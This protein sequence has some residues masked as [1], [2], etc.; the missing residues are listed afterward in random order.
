MTS[1]ARQPY[2]A[3]NED[4]SVEVLIKSKK[5]V[6]AHGEVFTPGHM[7]NQMLDLVQAELETEPDFVDKTF[8]EPSAGDGNFLIAILNR[9]LEA[10]TVHYPKSNHADE[11][12][13]ALAS[14]YGIELLADNHQ[15]AQAGMLDAFVSFHEEH[16]VPCTP[17]TDLYSA[18][19]F[20]IKTNIVHGNTL[21]GLTDA[22]DPIIF[23]WWHRVPEEE[24]TVQR[25]DFALST[26]RAES[27]GA[28]DFNIYTTYKPCRIDRVHQE[29]KRQ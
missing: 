16:G 14:I 13:F 15:A 5:R 25:E 6:R 9:K 27:Q 28:I 3:D 18:A 21:T 19:D 1:V 10:I 7:V 12:L 23:S 29:G 4:E 11:S 17:S 22:G 20:L 24:A 8:L 2:S 26:L